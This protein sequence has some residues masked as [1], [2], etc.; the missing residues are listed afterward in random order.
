MKY[1][2]YDESGIVY[3]TYSVAPPKNLL[4]NNDYVSVDFLDDPTIKEGKKAILKINKENRQPF[5]EYIDVPVSKEKTLEEKIQTLTEN[6]AKEKINNM[7][8][9]SLATKLTKE[10]ANLK[11]EV[12]K[13]KK[14]GNE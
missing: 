2:F 12:M 8:K 14:G 11:I 9:D 3:L 10:L 4:D 1:L 6:L 7:K 13:L 5:Y